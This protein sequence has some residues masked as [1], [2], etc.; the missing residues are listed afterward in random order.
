MRLR[1]LIRYTPAFCMSAALLAACG[2]AQSP[3]GAPSAIAQSRV[4]ASRTSSASYTV[5]YNFGVPP[6]GGCPHASLIDVDGT[7]YGT[8]SGG[9]DQAKYECSHLLDVH[10]TVFRI[11]TDGKEKV[12]HSFLGRPDGNYPLAG[13][14]D[15]KGKLYGT[16]SLGGMNGYGTLFSITTSGTEK[17][18]YSFS[19][20]PGGGNPAASLIDAKGNFYGTT[21]SGGARRHDTG[22]VFS[23]T[24]GGTEDVLHNF[25]GHGHVGSHPVAALIDAGGMLYGTMLGG[26][27]YG[28]G[29]VFRITPSGRVNV[30]HSF[31]SGTD[32]AGPL[33][34]LIDVGGTFYGTTELG[35]TSGNGTVF[36]ITP[37]GTENV[38]YSFGPRPDGASPL[39]SLI[40]VE[41]TLFGTTTSGGANCGASYGC[42][43]V[44][45]ITTDGTE[46]V[47]HS[48]GSG[49]DGRDPAAALTDVN[50]SLYGT[51]EFGGTSGNGTV[52]AL[53]P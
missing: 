38:L 6:D 15:V 29:V 53:T 1:E 34:S 46:T 17:L 35:G 11:T 32:G 8:T 30:L 20:V 37:S 24:K 2:G 19:N 47:L 25:R 28:K 4:I 50:G 36:S 18:L 12:L 45:S 16:T 9:G 7:L 51:T 5:I 10:G 39:A 27:A 31:G 23:F 26:G 41:G 44:F 48:F 49:T 22:T 40:D 13:L 42:G 33:A 21:P 14:T 3:I 43:T 52:F